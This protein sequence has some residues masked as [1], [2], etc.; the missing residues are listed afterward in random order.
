[1]KAM[2]D[3]GEERIR[4][5]VRAP[6]QEAGEGDGLGI[7]DEFDAVGA[8]P[9]WVAVG[10]FVEV[11]EALLPAVDQLGWAVVAG[12]P[13]GCQL[14]GFVVFP[15]E[16][17]GIGLSSEEPSVPVVGVQYF[18]ELVEWP[19]V[20]SAVPATVNGGDALM[21]VGALEGHAANSSA[22]C[23]EEAGHCLPCGSDQLDRQGRL[24]GWGEDLVECGQGSLEH[25]G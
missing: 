9:V 11:G 3:G 10:V 13:G 5:L 15:A 1:M 12:Q 24:R 7:G 16:E 14:L 23:A 22:G 21:W 4:T 20:A 6:T 17:Q 2:L 8:R 19:Q 25:G 18:R